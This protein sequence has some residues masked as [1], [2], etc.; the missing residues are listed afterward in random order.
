MPSK[1]PSTRSTKA[2][3]FNIRHP[4]IE[5]NIEV[6]FKVKGK[7]YYRFKDDFRMPVGRYKYVYAYLREVDLRMSL[8]TLQA[9]VQE[10]KRCLNGE[11]KVI[12]LEGAFKI[13]FS[14]ETRVNLAFEPDGV[15]RLA[16]VTYFD[17][18]EDLSTY[19]QK[20]GNDKIVFWK[21]NNVTDFFLTR[22]INELLGLTDISVT[23]LEEYLATAQGILQDLN[24]ELP[25]L[26]SE[27]SSGNGRK[28]L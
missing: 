17:S 21:K 6:A 8:G 7:T 1:K 16:A 2:P 23:S 19:D 13:V 4:D 20:Y 9:Y 24:L 10:L 11:K 14:L 28:T 27:S 3:I 5:N 26:S 18:T 22:P 25:N 15:R 12:D